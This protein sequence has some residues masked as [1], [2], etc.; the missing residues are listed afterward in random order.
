MLDDI[1]LGVTDVDHGFGKIQCPIQEGFGDRRIKVTNVKFYESVLA[2][3]WNLLEPFDDDSS[4]SPLVVSS[5]FRD[6][7]DN[8]FENCFADVADFTLRRIN[9]S[10][11]WAIL[12]V[13]LVILQCDESR[14]ASHTLDSVIQ[15]KSFCYFPRFNVNIGF[16]VCVTFLV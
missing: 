15:A 6:F 12:K 7:G 4:V 5:R 10:A 1:Y 13:S 16:S 3:A 9:Q 2:L 11:G 8:V 14:F